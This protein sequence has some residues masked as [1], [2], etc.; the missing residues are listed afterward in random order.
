MSTNKSYSLGNH[1][2]Q[3]IESQVFNGRFNNGSKVVRAGL[4]LLEDYETR[5]KELRD[6]IDKGDSAIAEGKS[7]I[8][9]SAEHLTSDIVINGAGQGYV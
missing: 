6:L 2:E 3:F 4:R 8:Y 7:K 9:T 5:M 1:Y